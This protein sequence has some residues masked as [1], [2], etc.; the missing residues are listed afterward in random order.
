M[1]AAARDAVSLGGNV[2]V[3]SP[4]TVRQV[5]DGTPATLLS[6]QEAIREALREEMRRDHVPSS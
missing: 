3:M 1:T 4:D 6:Y 5:P 2:P